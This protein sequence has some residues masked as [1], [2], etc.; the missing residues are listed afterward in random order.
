ME[1]N[2]RPRS[3]E[4]ETVLLPLAVEIDGHTFHE[5]TLEQVTRRNR[6]DRDVQIAGYTVMHFSYSELVRDP[7]A[8]AAEVSLAAY[9]MVLE[10]QKQQ[11][12]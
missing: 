11:G 6:R 9:R 8:C 3:G 10:Q 4:L 5:K 12:K 1:L 2:L 7:M